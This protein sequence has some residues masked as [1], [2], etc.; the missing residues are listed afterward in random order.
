MGLA[1]DMDKN[2]GF[3]YFRKIALYS[4]IIEYKFI[5]LMWQVD[6]TLQIIL[7]K[8]QAN[9]PICQRYLPLKRSSLKFLKIPSLI[10]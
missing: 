5:K 8:W 2:I 4:P 10:K 3:G 1:G 9:R 7:L 6:E